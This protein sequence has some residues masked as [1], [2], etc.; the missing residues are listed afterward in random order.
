MRRFLLVAAAVALSGT[1]ASAQ[2]PNGKCPLPSAVAR[3]A[4]A[5]PVRT[6][7]TATIHAGRD[8]RHHVGHRLA[9]ARAA[10]AGLVFRPYR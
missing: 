4:A 7:T 9:H 6:L 1:V 3:L 8:V 5:T 2:C 10:V